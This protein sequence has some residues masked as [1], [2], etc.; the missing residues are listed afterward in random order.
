MWLCWIICGK[1]KNESIWR[2]GNQ[3]LD[4]QLKTG[5]TTSWNLQNIRFIFRRDKVML[6]VQSD[7]I[8]DAS[9]L[10]SIAIVMLRGAMG[11]DGLS[12]LQIVPF[13]LFFKQSYWLTALTFIHGSI[14]IKVLSNVAFS[15]KSHLQW[16]LNFDLESSMHD[17][18][19][20]SAFRRC[21]VS[22]TATSVSI[23]V[24]IS[25]TFRRDASFFAIKKRKKMISKH[26]Y[27]YTD[28]IKVRRILI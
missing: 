24:S 27:S 18:P 14:P 16:S 28:F 3:L 23:T 8:L 6:G 5:G 10:K 1:K 21:S 17:C 13:V 11:V 20:E 15:F 4:W 2:S 12:K 19:G 9:C 7:K 22:A 26:H 25:N